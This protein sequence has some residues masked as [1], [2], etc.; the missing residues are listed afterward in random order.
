MRWSGELFGYFAST[1]ADDN[2]VDFGLVAISLVEAFF[3]FGDEVVVF[4]IGDEVD[5]AA[6]ET[7]AH[8]TRTGDATFFSDVVEEVEFFAA[9]FVVFREPLV[10]FVHET[11]DSFVVAAVEGVAYVEDAFF[12]FDYEF[13][14]EV[15]FGGDVGFSGVECFFSSVAES[16]DVEAFS[17]AFA[18]LATFVVGRV[19]EFVFN[20]RVDEDEFVAL[21]VEGEVFK[22]HR[23]A[24]EAH[25]VAFFAEDG[26]ELVHNAA[27]YA[28]VVVFGRLA[29]AGEL[30]FVDGVAIEEVVE[31]ES[32]AAFEGCRRAKTCA[33]GDIAGE[34]GVEAFYDAATFD[35]FAADTEYV[36]SPLLFRSIFFVESKLG[37]V[38]DIDRE[39]AHFFSVVG[40]NSRHDNFIDSTGE[41]VTAVVVGVFADKVDTTGRSVKDAFATEMIFELALDFFFHDIMCFIG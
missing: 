32:E 5:G 1:V 33:E 8:D 17:Y 36:S 19:D 3:S 13:S 37:V 34:N 38:V 6:A 2:V 28:A 4:V 7:A 16:F 31:S 15:V 21:G 26:S 20:D 27:V 25:E 35:S 41:N 30:E 9:H 39:Y 18:R 12:F 10:G 22:F 24:V 11:T 23:A 14:A 40:A 29:N